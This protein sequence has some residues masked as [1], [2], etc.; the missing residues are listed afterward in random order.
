MDL[1]TPQSQ[2]PS[3]PQLSD[4]RYENLFKLYQ[5]TDGQYFYNILSTA[6]FPDNLD[7]NIFYDLTVN[8][9]TPWPLISYGAYGT[10]ELWWLIAIINGIQN[11]FEL[12]SNQS[13]KILK[14]QYIRQVITQLNQLIQ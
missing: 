10:I 1:G 12:P 13:I 2:I 9:K 3:L 7:K 11:P 6:S 14:P 8:E 4:F 5:T